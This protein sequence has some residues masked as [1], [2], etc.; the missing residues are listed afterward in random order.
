MLLVGDPERIPLLADPRPLR[1]HHQRQRLVAA[2][3]DLP[4]REARPAKCAALVGKADRDEGAARAFRAVLQ[5]RRNAPLR[6]GRPQTAHRI[7]REAAQLVVENDADSLAALGVPDRPFVHP[8]SVLFQQ[9]RLKA[10]LHP[11]G[12]VGAARHERLLAALAIDG[13]DDAVFR[14]GDGDEIDLSDT[15]PAP[16]AASR[17]AGG[18]DGNWSDPTADTNLAKAFQKSAPP[19]R[20]WGEH[21]TPVPCS[22]RI[23]V[24]ILDGF[25]ATRPELVYCISRAPT[26]CRA[27]PEGVRTEQR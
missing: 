12:I 8:V 5:R 15:G 20:D 3:G 18:E 1:Q 9:Q 14:V 23:R 4:R 22:D 7:P 16:G 19:S 10:D 17:C 11:F 24:A 21:D 25:V 26:R 27:L 13:R 2:H 6:D